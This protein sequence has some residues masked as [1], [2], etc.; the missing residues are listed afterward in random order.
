MAEVNAVTRTT[1][2]H[3]VQ[4]FVNFALKFYKIRE[5]CLFFK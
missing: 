2:M 1:K 5:N 3:T 4:H